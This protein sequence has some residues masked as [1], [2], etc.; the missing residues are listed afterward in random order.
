MEA[1]D[2]FLEIFYDNIEREGSEALLEWLQKSD[3]FDAPASTNN[4][5]AF[6]GGL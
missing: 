6:R 2:E 4:H 1:K 5:S 3:F